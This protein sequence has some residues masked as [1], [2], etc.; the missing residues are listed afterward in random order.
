ML[1][2]VCH[3][4]FLEPRFF[5]F[6]VRLVRELTCYYPIEFL[7]ATEGVL[8]EVCV[9][10]DPSEAEQVRCDDEEGKKVHNTV[11][12]EIHTRCSRNRDR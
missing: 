2:N 12:Q 6:H 11:G 4:P 1:S 9:K 5:D 7:A 8:D 3:V 10:S